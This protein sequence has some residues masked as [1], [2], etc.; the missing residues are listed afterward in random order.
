MAK[1]WPL[2]FKERLIM[3]DLSSNVGVATLWMPKESVVSELDEGSF[4][5]CG[6]LYTKRGINP[7]LRNLLANTLIRYVIVCGVDRQGS[8]EALLKFFKNGVSEESGGAGELKGW[9]ILGDDEALLDKEITKEALDLIRI[10]VEVFD[11]RMKPLGEVNGLIASLEKKVPYAEPVLFPEPA[12]DEVKQYPSDLSVFKLRRETIADAWLDA[13]KVVNRFGVEIP[14]MYGQVKE[15]HNLSIVIEKED[16]KSPKLEPFLKFG[17]EGLDLYIK[18][19]FD[20]E[21]S[22]SSY[23]YGERI[24]DW[25]GIDQKK[26]MVEKLSRF[27]FDR[28]ALA[29]L[30]KP[31][32]DNYP[33][34][35]TEMAQNGQTKGWQ[36]PC[37]VMIMGQCI[38]DNFHMTAVFRNN[39][40][41]GGWPLNAFA[42]RNL[43][44]NIAVEVGKNLG[45]LTTISHIAEIYE[46]DYEDAKKVVAENDSLARTCLYDTRGYYTISIEG[47]DIVV[48]FFTPDGS[49]ELATFRENGKKP[50]AARDLC[51]MVLRDMLLSELG[52]A[53]DLGRQLAKAETA[54]KLGL[55]FEQDQ[56]LRLE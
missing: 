37:L 4:S 29:V 6:Q 7:L 35:E 17:K 41:Y 56:P 55:V 47:E 30:W 10:N 36:V 12:K 53:A 23:T 27:P 2:Y 25:D 24:L 8:G 1:D 42:L 34:T 9:K 14:G 31:H 11:L 5:V 54:V 44:Q 19:F 50:K 46:I 22:G 32:R 3:G 21:K 18:G 39:D 13:L 43:Q 26:I 16:P 49:E 38:G 52:A 20:T 48:T 28:G 51:A 15:V 40:I 45:A 33:P